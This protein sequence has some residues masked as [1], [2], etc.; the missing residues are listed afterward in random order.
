MTGSFN[1]SLTPSIRVSA[2]SPGGSPRS[3]LM[4]V[5]ANG[6]SR[7]NVS[8]SF[9]PLSRRLLLLGVGG[10][11]CQDG[12]GRALKK[13]VPWRSTHGSTSAACPPSPF[14]LSPLSRHASQ[15]ETTGGG[16]DSPLIDL[17]PGMFR[18]PLGLRAS[19]V[20]VACHGGGAKGLCPGDPEKGG[21]EM[22]ARRM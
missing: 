9:P 21:I 17:A 14:H 13:R 1:C 2:S 18:G 5:G 20:R 15:C 12:R 10:R 3:S 16:F 19:A 8:R 4:D 11:S 6:T 7:L 22:E